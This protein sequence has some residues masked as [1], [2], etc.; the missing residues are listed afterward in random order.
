MAGNMQPF[1]NQTMICS[2]IDEIDKLERHESMSPHELEELQKKL[3]LTAILNSYKNEDDHILKEIF[4]KYLGWIEKNERDENRSLKD[5]SDLFIFKCGLKNVIAQE[6][7]QYASFED[8]V[9]LSEIWKQPLKRDRESICKFL[10]FF[11]YKFY[12]INLNFTEHI[13][14]IL[15]SPWKP[16]RSPLANI[17]TRSLT[18]QEIEQYF[19]GPQAQVPYSVEILQNSDRFFS[20]TSVTDGNRIFLNKQDD[21]DLFDAALVVHEFQHIQDAKVSSSL[22][23]S[24]RAALNAEKIFLHSAGAGKRGKYCW[25]ESNLLYPLI[26]LQCELESLITGKPLFENLGEVCL[27]HHMKP[28]TLSSLFHWQAPFQMAVYCAA[29][30][31]LEPGWKKIFEEVAV[32]YDLPEQ[33]MSLPLQ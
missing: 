23:V 22:F 8:L 14:S 5:R 31:D 27:S 30:M 1:L 21:F 17:L 7:T 25:L 4:K 26:L 16:A 9:S 12:G 10:S 29:V 18:L 19:F 3:A 11:M 28:I 15:N 2:L 20:L 33:A 24:E 32:E 13:F 6:K